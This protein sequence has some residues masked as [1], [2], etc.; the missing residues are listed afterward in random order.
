MQED[1]LL[2]SHTGLF[3]ED[4]ALTPNWS[5]D[6][7][8]PTSNVIFLHIRLFIRLYGST[9]Y[10]VQELQRPS[11]HMAI[12]NKAVLIAQDL[13]ALLVY[14][15][16]DHSPITLVRC[17]GNWLKELFPLFRERRKGE[18]CLFVMPN[19]STSLS[20]INGDKKGTIVPSSLDA[21]G[22]CLCNSVGRREG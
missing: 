10:I 21:K 5:V 16:S 3:H 4:L 17:H 6:V 11:P 20:I 19:L 7:D 2:F 14:V 13:N 8:V 15:H 9:M 1:N 22:L 18:E 12:V